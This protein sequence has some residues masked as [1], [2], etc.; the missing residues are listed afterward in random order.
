MKPVNILDISDKEVKDKLL[1]ILNKINSTVISTMG[2]NGNTAVLFDGINSPHI[3]KDGVSVS[4][5][6]NFK[7]PFEQAINLIVKETARKTAKTVGDGTTTSIL[8]AISLIKSIFA[9]SKNHTSRI[10][11]L[12]SVKKDIDIIIDFIKRNTINVNSRNIVDAVAN[13]SSNGD[14]EVTDIIAHAIDKI[15]FEGILEVEESESHQT[16]VHIT[17]GM[18]MYTKAHVYKTEEL[19]KPQVVLC[20]DKI[21]NISSIKSL[22][23]I[24]NS[25]KTQRDGSI[26][27]IAKEFTKDIVD[28]IYRNNAM[29]L[30]SL[31]LVE[32]DGFAHTFYDIMD[33]MSIILNTKVLTTDVNSANLSIMNLQ[34]DLSVVDKAI[35]S[36]NQTVLLKDKMLEDNM[37]ALERK[38]L[39]LSKIEKIKSSGDSKTGELSQLK[40]RLSKFNKSATIRVGGFTESAMKEQKDRID[41]AVQ[42]VSSAIRSGVVPGAGYI[43]YKAWVEEKLKFSSSHMETL[44]KSPINVLIKDTELNIDDLLNLYNEGLVVDLRTGKQG[45]PLEL[46]I[47]DPVDV[48]IKALQ[49]ALAIATTILNSKNFIITEDD[50]WHDTLEE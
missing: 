34:E 33:D 9:V 18:S 39:I 42:A 26:I 21:S 30:T 35:I 10:Q 3:T 38:K 13:I 31:F 36:P 12:K 28:I 14:T 19:Y 43:L 6:L 50:V 1:R 16:T 22:L 44:C 2:P 49:Q 41:D 4:E 45:L 23:K 40:K 20:S 37:D 48:Q 32:A 46:G 11:H 17:D 24:A 27:L 29:N 47:L 15:G 8:L 25:V 5:F 7:D